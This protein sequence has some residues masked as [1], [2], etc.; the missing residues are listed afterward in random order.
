M[1]TKEYLTLE[2]AT[3]FFSELYG[4]EHHIPGYKVK[5]YGQGFTI[6]HDRGDL[7][8]YDFNQLTKLVLMAHDKCIRVSVEGYA[9]RKMRISI[10][11]R[12]GREGSMS[13]R[14]PTIEKAIEDYNLRK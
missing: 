9:S 3:D 12:Q 13:L 8:T 7:A 6:I 11:K 4:G 1:E 10:W 14:H 5:P 2:Q